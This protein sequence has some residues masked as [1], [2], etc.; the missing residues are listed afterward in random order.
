MAIPEPFYAYK[1]TR[2]NLDS[3][4]QGSTVSINLPSLSGATP[5]L[6]STNKRSRAPPTPFAE[7]D[8]AF[9]HRYLATAAS[10]YHR[11][12]DNFPASYLWRILE[13][14]NV[15]SIRAIDVSRPV[16]ADDAN[17][18]LRLTLPCPVRPGCIALSDCKE[19]DV[20]SVFIYTES[21]HLYTLSLRP[22][23]FRKPI[24]TKDNVADWCK[25]YPVRLSFKQAHRMVALSANELFFSWY[26]GSHIK[27]TRTPGGDGK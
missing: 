14:G 15:F 27:L 24:S 20:L 2:L 22:D 3:A 17:L 8:T 26:D 12:Q 21:A 16:I 6:R 25:V 1:E 23:F 5:V 7:D 18:T 19:H 11:T 10:I 13:D 4:F 9:R